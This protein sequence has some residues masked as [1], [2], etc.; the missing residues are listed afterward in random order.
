MWGTLPTEKHEM[1]S[2]SN[3]EGEKNMAAMS[4]ETMCEVIKSCAYGYTVDE[5]AEHYGMEKTDAEKF[6]KDHA[7]EITE[8]KEHLKQ[9][10]YIE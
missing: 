5:L 7:S 8:T 9:E 6:V 4:E 10:G 2:L 3:R 1:I